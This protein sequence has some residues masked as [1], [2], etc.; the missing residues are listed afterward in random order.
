M[1]IFR[2]TF[3]DFVQ[4]E[5]NRRQTLIGSVNGQP[6]I[7][8]VNELTTRN[9]WV[10]MTSGV[11]VYNNKTQT[12]D[13][14]LAKQYVLQGGTL[15]NNTSL[16]S[17]I[18]SDFNKNVY[19]NTSALGELYA[20]GIRPMPGITNIS[21][22][23]KTAY[24]SLVEATVNFTCWDIKQLEDLELLYMRPGYTVLLEWG[25]AYSGR[26]PQYYDILEKGSIDY[27]SVVQ[28]LF[29]K[30]KENKGNYEA[31]FG[32]VKNYS[33][34]ARPDGGYDC[35]THIISMG[36]VLE[37]L[38]V[39]YAPYNQTY[40][41]S[42]G[43]N[44][45]GLLQNA[46]ITFNSKSLD[47]FHSSANIENIKKYYSKGILTGLLYEL[48]LFL[49]SD[50]PDAEN[51]SEE[52]PPLII[53]N[54]S[55]Y[56]FKK[57]WNFKNIEEFDI[58]HTISGTPDQYHYY[59]T[60][61]SLCNL[62]NDYVLFKNDGG[63]GIIE[64]STKGRAYSN[65]NSTLKCVAHPLQTSTD[66]TKCLIRPDVWMNGIGDLA[67]KI[68]DNTKSIPPGDVDQ[69]VINWLNNDPQG[70]FFQADYVKYS[71]FIDL[72][73]KISNKKLIDDGTFPNILNT[74]RNSLEYSIYNAS[75]YSEGGNYLYSVYNFRDT[76][77]N[78]L[79]INYNTD[80]WKIISKDR[81]FNALSLISRNTTGDS[82]YKGIIERVSAE[83]SYQRNQ[84]LFN[85]PNASEIDIQKYINNTPLFSNPIITYL[86]NSS[87]NNNNKGIID[88]F[89]I[90]LG[91]P[92][93]KTNYAQQLI[94]KLTQQ[95]ISQVAQEA[96]KAFA[97]LN[98]LKP[99]FVNNDYT[100]GEI[101]NIYL[102]MANLL[103][104]LESKNIESKDRQGRNVISVIDFMQ[105]VLR[106][107]QE[108]TGNIN[109][110]DLH[111]DKDSI[112]RTIDVNITEST[113]DLFKIQVHNTNSIVRN[114]N[115][116]SKIFPEQGT[117]IAISAQ[118]TPGE[119]GYDNSTMVEYNRGISD[120]LIPR[121]QTNI[122][123]NQQNVII[124]NIYNNF[125][126]IYQY[127]SFFNDSSNKNAAPGQFN[128][129][130]RDLIGFFSTD[131]NNRISKSIIPVMFSFD[132]DGIGGIV[133]GN[134]FSINEDVLPQGYKS[135][136]GRKLG[137]LVKAFN[138]KV[139]NNDW[140]TTIEAYPF[141]IDNKKFNPSNWNEILVNAFKQA[142]TPTT[143][144]PIAFNKINIVNLKA[145]GTFPSAITYYS[146]GKG[147]LTLEG[148]VNDRYGNTI[149]TIEDY[150]E[151]RAPYVTVA[152]DQFTPSLNHQV[153]TN[154][155]FTDSTGKLIPFKVEDTGGA[156]N[157]KGL[158]RIDIATRSEQAAK[159]GNLIIKGKKYPIGDPNTNINGWKINV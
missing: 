111:I 84:A 67:Q 104:I 126:Q 61:E 77:G 85:N 63:K 17:G 50:I 78:D 70:G 94:A 128:N 52:Y 132:M 37:S 72:L 18:G 89:N 158:S 4:T 54:K 3:P 19:S 117:I 11:N 109:N 62:I 27:Q 31:I 59:I 1:S 98:H 145:I 29:N 138:N 39:N 14:S 26:M 155:S 99:Y 22:E 46:K 87:K 149:Y 153:L 69:N 80:D 23:C 101:S 5:L 47:I 56:V 142:S 120:R 140:I 156:F 124:K 71:K 86:Y 92:P 123:T 55:Y 13:N 28:D 15:N 110:F 121:K 33:W 103:Y 65:D 41:P 143:P 24:G 57:K 20:R 96:K 152:M 68:S 93:F 154:P 30:S 45:I 32:Y 131:P 66:P 106:Q 2:Q 100:S 157:N 146:P 35:T 118:S 95:T 16:K 133:I 112:G 125:L 25:W 129:A 116:E 74:I 113:L 148:G 64:L 60:L 135:Q 102:D 134:L 82:L 90:I 79:I 42:D 73:I 127:F 83:Y 7:N 114:Y 9:A 49:S 12:Y 108:C 44:T 107:V 147:N 150:L 48:N 115:L 151:G 119:M 144:D 75:V 53:N 137:F 43:S 139:E 36:E 105:E 51:I 122:N 38:K 6:R 159:S 88:N 81:G 21:T 141:I 130:L 8:L 10:R 97:G 76:Q 91:N 136:I 58:S 40:I 34:K